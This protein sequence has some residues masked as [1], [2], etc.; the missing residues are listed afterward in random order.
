MSGA[1]KLS[2]KQRQVM[3]WWQKNYDAIICDGA[4]RSGKTFCMG[5]AFLLWAMTCFHGRQ[6]ALCG[7]TIG[8]LRRNLLY[9]ALPEVERVGVRC[10]ERRSE[11]SFTL[12]WGGRSN[13]FLLFGGQ[14]EGSAALIQGVTL[15]GLLLDEAAL[16]PRSF[17]E[18]ACARCSVPGSKLWFNCNPEGPEH[19]FY[20]E[21]IL[22]AEERRALYLH[23]TM[24]DNPGL[25]EAVRERYQRLYSGIFYRRFVLGEWVTAEGRVYDFFDRRRDAAPVPPGRMEAWRVSVD[26]GTVNPTSMGLW[27]RRN[28][29]WYRVKEFYYDSRREGR[30]KTD[31][32]YVR[33]LRALCGGKRVERVIVDPSAA[34]FLAA[35]RQAGFPVKAADNRVLDGIR[36]TAGM[37]REGKIILCEPCEDCLREMGLYC[38]ESGKEV[39]RKENDH[40]MDDLRYFAMDLQGE[41][42]RFAATYV[43]RRA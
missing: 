32:E 16:M 41:T 18:Q 31:A 1:R 38:W 15:A 26:Y 21:W 8:A 11:N 20:R 29:V 3:L 37:L 13:R 42:R 17:V 7:K 4:V 40:A 10:E 14:D 28:G 19:W 30:Q 43:E 12:R 27:G 6:F 25:D 2:P 34:S 9:D 33:D 39:P 22:K 23:F 36:V 5:V 35:L 24:E